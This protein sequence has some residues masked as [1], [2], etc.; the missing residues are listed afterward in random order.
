MPTTKPQHVFLFDI[1]GTLLA[2][3]GAGKAAMEQALLAAFGLDCIGV[4]VP[5]A[6]RTDVA[7][8]K[9]L[10]SAHGV[11][12]TPEHLECLRETYLALLP[13]YLVRHQGRVLPGVAELLE[14]LQGRDDVMVGLLTG[15]VRRGAQVKLGHFEIDHHFPFGGFGDVHLDRD[16]VARDALTALRERHP[17]PVCLEQVWVIGDTPSDVRCARAIGARAVA[18]ATGSHKLDDLA[19]TQPDLLLADLADTAGL[20]AHCGC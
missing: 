8:A 14:S 9:D 2:S 3:G 19:T 12:P 16:D 11:E 15:N 7:I 18:V 5:Y 4:N 20:L 13:E 6:G 17:G 10:L 1:D